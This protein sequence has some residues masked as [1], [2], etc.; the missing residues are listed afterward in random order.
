M[1]AESV[2]IC[3]DFYFL[4]LYAE[5]TR[6]IWKDL[7]QINT[8]AAKQSLI[9]SMIKVTAFLK[10]IFFSVNNFVLLFFFVAFHTF[11]FNYGRTLLFSV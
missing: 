7:S 1:V 9:S 4:F 5:Q 8:H 2:C 10:Q 6:G 3:Y 11:R